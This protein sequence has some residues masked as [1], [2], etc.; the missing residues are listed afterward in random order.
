MKTPIA[1][2]LN[3]T[4]RMACGYEPG[5]ELSPVWTGEFDFKSSLY[6]E[7]LEEVFR[8][9]NL[10]KPSDYGYRSLSVGDVVCVGADV[11]EKW[12]SCEPIGWKEIACPLSEYEVPIVYHG[13][14][15]YIVRAPN[16]RLA[17]E[18]AR[19]RFKNGEDGEPLGNEWEQI[20]R[21]GAVERR[22]LDCGNCQ[23]P[24][25]SG[26]GTKNNLFCSAHCENRFRGNECPVELDAGGKP[27]SVCTFC[28]DDAQAD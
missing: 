16:P 25:P 15:N 12:F 10:E 27:L 17:E 19:E 8:I 22:M 18:A 28:S 6:T 26:N 3:T 13:L 1:I 20:L 24:F 11:F 9:F 14:A 2:Y 21:V 4:A 5:D 23:Q 7:I